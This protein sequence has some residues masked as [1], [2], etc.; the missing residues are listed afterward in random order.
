MLGARSIASA[1][2]RPGPLA[3]R[4]AL[5]S[6]P[7]R[8]ANGAGITGRDVARAVVD[9]LASEPGI[10]KT[11]FADFGV[12][13]WSMAVFKGDGRTAIRGAVG[14]RVSEG[15]FEASG[16]ARLAG[17]FL[18]ASDR[19]DVAVVNRALAQQ[20]GGDGQLVIGFGRASTRVSVVGVVDTPGFRSDL[21]I[22]FLP[23]VAGPGPPRTVT[24]IARAGSLALASQAIRR[25]MAAVAPAAPAD[26]ID[27]VA[28]AIDEAQAGFG[29]IV[30]AGAVASIA[31]ILMAA[32]GIFAMMTYTVERR[33]KEIGIRLAIGASRSAIVR[34]VVV[35]GAWIF[36]IGVAAGVG[37]GVLIGAALRSTLFVVSPL[38]P[39][40]IAPT[41]GVLLL[42]AVAATVAPTL[43]ATRV[44]ALAVIRDGN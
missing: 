20:I 21:P 32:V 31:A 43:A 37:I 38:D 11:G 19:E 13:P 35:A 44:D 4:T 40:G 3:D 24:V 14:G 42:V 29:H 12:A 33:T 23:L 17:R 30:D 5:F 9:L 6:L 26:R 16:S 25:A 10:E 36:A 41:V 18:A 7:L 27:S 39:G 34:T 15:W 2:T 8:D 22:V 28:S 1:I